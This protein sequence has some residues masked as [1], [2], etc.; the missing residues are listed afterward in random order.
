MSSP[1]EPEKV[2]QFAVQKLGKQKKNET[3]RRENRLCLSLQFIPCSF[4][5]ERFRSHLAWSPFRDYS[6]QT[7]SC[8]ILA[9]KFYATDLRYAWWHSSFP[10]S[11]GSASLGSSLITLEL[12]D[13]GFCNLPAFRRLWKGRYLWLFRCSLLA[14]SEP[15]E[16]SK[17]G[18]WFWSQFCP[19][20]EH[21]FGF[22]VYRQFSFQ[23]EPPASVSPCSW[24]RGMFR[25]VRCGICKYQSGPFMGRACLLL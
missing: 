17:K 13:V 25:T 9:C 16:Q 24:L 3:L 11:Y 21:L 18:F 1:S 23:E 14:W 10:G 4:F 15:G 6:S 8:F 22:Q 20:L 5:Q 2:V 7:M 19:H 12:K